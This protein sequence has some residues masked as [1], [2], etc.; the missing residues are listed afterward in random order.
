MNIILRKYENDFENKS[1]K[2]LEIRAFSRF[3]ANYMYCGFVNVGHNLQKNEKIVAIIDKVVY[4]QD[5]KT[6]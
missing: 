6:I 3:S 1:R 4:Y 5:T 2:N